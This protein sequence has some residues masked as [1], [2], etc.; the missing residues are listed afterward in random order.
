MLTAFHWPDIISHCQH[1]FVY[2][3]GNTA[4]DYGRNLYFVVADYGHGPPVMFVQVYHLVTPSVANV[5][6]ETIRSTVTA[7]FT[8]I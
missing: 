7:W 3:S 1:V 6:Y 5:L 2:H 8:T 4:Q